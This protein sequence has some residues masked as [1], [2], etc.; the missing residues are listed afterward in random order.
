MIG[1]CVARDEARIAL[2]VGEEAVRFENPLLPDTRSE[3]ALPLRARG[4]VIGAMTVQSAEEAAFDQ[5][6]IATLQ[7]MA[8][9]VA[10]AIDNARLFANTERA[11]QG[12]EA[13]QHRYL[14]QEWTAYTQDMAVRGYECIEA[15]MRPLGKQVLPEVR[16]AVAA[17]R[18]VV[19][20][21]QRVGATSPSVLAAPII[22]G[23]RI[24][25]TLGFRE[26]EGGRLWGEEDV[27]L[28]RAIAEQFSLAAENLRL[29]DQTQRGEA[30][31]RLTREIADD[32]RAA[33]S[34][35]DALKRAVRRLG[36]A[37]GAS[38]V[39]ARMGIEGERFS[40]QGGNGHE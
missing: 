15:G 21:G 14:G 26:G 32:I 9:Q 11:L 18:P 4:R 3:L 22:F 30:R 6:Y 38:E 5:E 23:D 25:G 37:L 8:D 36:Y 16:Q 28:A 40:G 34:V 10:V 39:V 13:A 1:Q 12:L 31:E 2:D 17:G 35:D 33:V 24:V 27:A 19:S 7:T 29:L 20:G